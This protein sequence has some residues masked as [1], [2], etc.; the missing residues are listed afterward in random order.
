MRK[1]FALLAIV[2]NIA[3]VSALS[4]VDLTKNLTKGSRVA[5]VLI[6]QNFLAS[7]GYLKAK[8]NGYFGAGTVA[9][10]KAYQRSVGLSAS[11]QVFPLTRAAI[12]QETCSDNEDT[13]TDNEGTIEPPT[14]ATTKPSTPVSVN[15]T[16]PLG[17]KTV[18]YSDDIAY[19]TPNG[20]QEN[21][22]VTIVLTDGVIYSTSF[23]YDNPT[24]Q[25]HTLAVLG[26]Q[27]VTR[28]LI[29]LGKIIEKAPR[30]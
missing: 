1:I 11:G 29:K 20:T 14:P 4:C 6:L 16:T 12:K 22:H 21:I 15:A 23:N 9:A 28:R 27:A 19:D 17:K 24:K 3:F 10:V 25:K 13:S 2:S 30:R 7:K 18:S 8:P 5:Q 26:R